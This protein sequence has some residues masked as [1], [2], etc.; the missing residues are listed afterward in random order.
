MRHVLPVLFLLSLSLPNS[1]ANSQARAA[2]PQVDEA[3]VER[4]DR[5]ELRGGGTVSVHPGTEPRV[6]L[7]DGAEH[8]MQVSMRSGTLLIECRRPC[9]NRPEGIVRVST[10]SITAVQISGGGTMKIS[11][12]FPTASELHARVR[13]GGSLDASALLAESVRAEVR[14]GGSVYVSP[15]HRLQ[16]RTRGGGSVAYFG[17]P[18]V[19]SAIRSGGSIRRAGEIPTGARSGVFRDPRDGQTYGTVQIGEQVWMNRNLAYLPHVCPA[20]ALDCGIWVYG[21][22][23]DDVGDAATTDEYQRYGALYDWKT[24]QEACPPGWHLPSDEEWQELEVALGMSPA[25]AATSV[26]RGTNEGDL[27]K[28]GGGSGLNVTFGG[29]RT[30]FGK[31][32]Y[33]G[34]HANFWCSDE[35][36][37]DHAC[38]RLVGVGRSDLGRH[39]GNKGAA[40]SVRCVQDRSQEPNH[41][42]QA[43]A[44]NDGSHPIRSA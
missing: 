27:V 24:A 39:T 26:W 8:T 33:I 29:W 7:L 23:G 11:E 6:A 19:T 32:N 40:F 36:D 20:D 28:V 44:A 13:G 38:E 9:P 17:D 22:D 1:T 34:E 31:F 2:A 4:F 43:S 25:D 37:E 18:E 15:L 3:V 14:G 42:H 35:A 41:Q 12:G 21:Y 30:G 5:V 16:A 10:P